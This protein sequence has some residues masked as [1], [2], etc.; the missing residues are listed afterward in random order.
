MIG[1]L[2]NS[3][4]ISGGAANGWTGGFRLMPGDRFDDLIRSA[5]ALSGDFSHL[6]VDGGQCAAKSGDAWLCPSV[7]FHL[8]LSIAS[9]KSGSVDLSVAGVPEPAT[10]ALLGIGF[11]GLGGFGL[12]R[13]A[14]SRARDVSD[15]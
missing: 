8:D 15:L 3:G 1:T 10:W 5:G 9:G 7:G 2:I 12:R 4:T 11:L 14:A 13:R 6:S